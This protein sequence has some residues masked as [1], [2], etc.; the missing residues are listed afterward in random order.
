MDNS[1]PIPTSR[2]LNCTWMRVGLFSLGICSTGLGIIGV[3]LP[4]MPSTVFFLI[5]L[6]AFSKSS[7]RM[8]HWLFSHPT[9]GRHVRDWHSHRVIPTRAKI[10]AVSMMSAS[11]FFVTFFIAESWMLP[12]ILALILGIIAAFIVTRDSAVELG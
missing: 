8:H 10:L 6:W 2:V 7:L 9:F 4:V 5:A 3:F 11:L 1:S 12:G